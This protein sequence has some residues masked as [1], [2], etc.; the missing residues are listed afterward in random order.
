ML[1]RIWF[2]EIDFFVKV[3]IDLELLV[4]ETVFC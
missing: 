1:R 4:V 3:F 2:V